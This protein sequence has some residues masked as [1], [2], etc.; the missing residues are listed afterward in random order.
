MVCGGARFR[1][2]G[3]MKQLIR[4]ESGYKPPVHHTN[5][6]SVFN[7]QNIDSFAQQLELNCFNHLKFLSC[8]SRNIKIDCYDQRINGNHKL[9]GTCYTTLRRLTSTE[10]PPMNLVNEDLQKTNPEHTTA[11]ILKV[12]KISV[13]EDVT[14]LDYIRNG[15]QMHFAVAIDFTASNGRHSHPSSLHYLSPE[16]QNF[17]EVAIRGVGEIVQHYNSS[18]LFP[19]FGTKEKSI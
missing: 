15:T 13:S 11:G 3:H 12:V 4:D 18:Q 7:G 9:I 14:F 8:Q 6:S 17:Y 2:E 16:R 19:A 5:N 10:E 1:F